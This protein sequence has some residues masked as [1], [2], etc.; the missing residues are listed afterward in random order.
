MIT[1][2]INIL[3]FLNII[4]IRLVKKIYFIIYIF[5]C[6]ILLYNISIMGNSCTKGNT[7]IE[8]SNDNDKYN[9]NIVKNHI[10]PEFQFKNEKVITTILQEK[11]YFIKRVP[12][13]YFKSSPINYNRVILYCE[14]GIVKRIPKNG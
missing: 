5:I 11:G 10:W 4:N 12:D 8:K 3:K 1:I 9:P 14:D 6:N 2:K 7:I 13:S